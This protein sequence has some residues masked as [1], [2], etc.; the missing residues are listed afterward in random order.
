MVPGH[1]SLTVIMYL[2]LLLSIIKKGK[3]LQITPKRGENQLHSHF[4][5][6]LFIAVLLSFGRYDED[7]SLFAGKIKEF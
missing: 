7:I 4:L 3:F 6:L 2:F 1:V 5:Q